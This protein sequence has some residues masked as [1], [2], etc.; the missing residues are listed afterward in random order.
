M[1][2]AKAICVVE[3]LLISEVWAFKVMLSFGWLNLRVKSLHKLLLLWRFKFYD[4]S[5]AYK[6]GNFALIM[7][8]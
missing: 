7:Q 4:V 1:K 3:G 2:L 5:F 8:T 6:I